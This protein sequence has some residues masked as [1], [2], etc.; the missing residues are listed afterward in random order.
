M[1]GIIA[2][3]PDLLKILMCPQTLVPLE[4]RESQLRSIGSQTIE[5]RIIE[6]IPWLFKDSNN[7]WLQ[8]RSKSI[9]GLGRLQRRIFA[10]EGILNTKTFLMEL[11]K[12]RLECQLNAYK[13]NLAVY[14][15]ILKEFL[16]NVK[17]DTPLTSLD[18]VPAQQ[19]I[20]SYADN[21]FRDWSWATSENEVSLE[22]L[23]PLLPLNLTGR[24]FLVLGSGSGR[25][26]IDFHR[27]LNP[28]LSIFIDFNPALMLVGQ[29]IWSG[30]HLELFEFPVNPVFKDKIA[31]KNL[32]RSPFGKTADIYPLFADVQNL[33]LMSSSIDCLITP[34]LVDIIP[35]DL[36]SF[37][38][39]LNRV[40]KMGGQWINFGP[41]AFSHA[42]ICEN[43]S[44]EEV[45]WILTESGFAITNKSVQTIPYLCSPNSGHLR[46]EKVLCFV[47]EKI[48]DVSPPKD[49]A[50]LPDWIHNS[51]QG[52]PL[53]PM[54]QE[55][56]LT[57]KVHAEVLGL[58]DG[59]RTHK[60]IAEIM[61]RHYGM[62][63]EQSADALKTLLLRILNYTQ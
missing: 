20:D 32:L 39:R 1:R 5:Y 63:F 34:W 26:G 38:R 42:D 52:I 30:G 46:N 47:A 45:L 61:S 6:G 12:E 44:Y 28:S 4:F 54:I 25:L 43:Y 41:L 19:K 16:V 24:N 49:F 27:L 10:L 33:P 21:I 3:N 15:D 22:T 58:I 14:Q 7:Q 40:L 18:L 2:M 23:K 48:A 62:S 35:D 53:T 50:L 36:M 29:K 13:F 56:Q 11:T 17:K 59:K 57:H 55:M 37:S 51:D 60:D 9:E 8:W 31:V